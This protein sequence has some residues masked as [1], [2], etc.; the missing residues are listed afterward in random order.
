[1]LL[2]LFRI[3]SRFPLSVL[4]ALGAALAWPV[5]FFASGY[6]Q[7]LR[8]NTTQAGYA[9]HLRAAVAESGKSIMELPFVWGAPLERVLEAARVENWELVQEAIDAKQGIIFLTP[10]LGCYEVVAQVIAVRTPLTVMYRPPGKES[11]KPIFEQGR[12]RANLLLAATNLSGVRTMIKALRGGG[13]IGLLP[14]HVPRYGDGVWAD[15]FGRPA[16]TMTLSA[17]L[18][19]MSGARI[20]L[21]YAERLPQGAGFVVRFVPFEE[22]MGESPEQ[23]ARAINAAMEKLIAHCPP[24]YFWS[25]SRYRT[26][27][28]TEKPER[29][30]V[31]T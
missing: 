17:K 14:D 27:A 5:Y 22:E 29:A 21:S 19:E 12:K 13:A 3:M 6:R 15:F 10:H 1:M 16:Y 2:F 8:E 24:Q 7:R 4:H 23:Q 26:P 18:H 11:H 31:D 20:I 25:Y 9:Q 30:K 28:G